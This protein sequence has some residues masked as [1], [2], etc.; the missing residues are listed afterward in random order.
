MYPCRTITPSLLTIYLGFIQALYGVNPDYHYQQSQIY[1]RAPGTC[2]WVL[3]HPRYV[4]WVSGQ[5][6]S[7]LWITGSPGLGKTVLA[8]FLTTTLSSSSAGIVCSFYFKSGEASREHAN[9]ALC[10]L[11]HQLW[12]KRPDLIPSKVFTDISGKGDHFTSI[13]DDLW[14]ALLET[15]RAAPDTPIFCI[16]DGLDEC[17][18]ASSS[19]LISHLRATFYLNNSNQ[20]DT[21]SLNLKF[22]ITSRPTHDIERSFEGFEPI[23][24]RGEDETI[25]VAKDVQTAISYRI[26]EMRTA[27]ALRPAACKLLE[28]RLSERSNDGSFL[29]VHLIFEKIDALLQKNRKFVDEVIETAPKDLYQLYESEL[30]AS[31]KMQHRLL[32]IILAAKRPLTLD[33]INIAMYI[34][35]TNDNFND[36]EIISNIELGVKGLG[37]ILIRVIN[38][39]VHLVH[40]TA[41][42]YLLNKRITQEALPR[43]PNGFS[44]E[45][46]RIMAEACVCFLACENWGSLN[47]SQEFQESGICFEHQHPQSEHYGKHR[48]NWYSVAPLVQ[49]SYMDAAEQELLGAGHFF[50]YAATNWFHH[51]S[52]NYEKIGCSSQDDTLK[53]TI[54]RLC[55]VG[56]QSKVPWWYFHDDKFFTPTSFHYWAAEGQIAVLEGIL[57]SGTLDINCRIFDHSVLSGAIMYG[58]DREAFWLIDH[59]H[60][61]SFSWEMVFQE[62]VENQR[63][64]LVSKLFQRVESSPT[65]LSTILAESLERPL[66][67]AV[68]KGATTMVEQLLKLGISPT[69]KRPFE[70]AAYNAHPH[71]LDLLLLH[72]SSTRSGP[73]L[74]SH[75]QAALQKAAQEDHDKSLSLGPYCCSENLQDDKVRDRLFESVN[76]ENIA[77]VNSF[78]RH[79]RNSLR[80][81]SNDLDYTV[82]QLPFG[83]LDYSLFELEQALGRALWSTYHL[84]SIAEPVFSVATVAALGGPKN[85]INYGFCRGHMDS[86][87]HRSLAEP[88][89][90]TGR[91][92]VRM[93]KDQEHFPTV[94]RNHATK[95]FL[96]HSSWGWD[97]INQ[98][99]TGSES[100]RLRPWQLLEYVF[101]SDP[102]QKFVPTRPTGHQNY[103]PNFDD[104]H[105]TTKMN[106]VWF[107]M[108][109]GVPALVKFARNFIYSNSLTT[110]EL[111]Y[112]GRC[113][114]THM[115]TVGTTKNPLISACLFG[116]EDLAALFIKLGFPVNDSTSLVSPSI[117]SVMSGN[118]K[119]VQLLQSYGA[120]MAAQGAYCLPYEHG[121]LRDFIPPGK[122]SPRK[123]IHFMA[124]RSFN[125]LR[126]QICLNH[127]SVT[128]SPLAFAMAL[129]YEDIIR[130]LVF[131]RGSQISVMLTEVIASGHSDATL[132]LLGDG[133]PPEASSKLLA[134]FLLDAMLQDMVDVSNRLVELGVTLKVLEDP[135]EVFKY[136]L[137]KQDLNLLQN[138]ARLG[139]DLHIRGPS[140]QTLLHDAAELG[141]L[142]IASWLLS[143]KNSSSIHGSERETA[144]SHMAT[145]VEDDQVESVCL[146]DV[147]FCGRTPLQY[148]VASGQLSIAKLLLE[149]KASVFHVDETGRSVLND[150][151]LSY[152]KPGIPRLLEDILNRL[153]RSIPPETDSYVLAEDV[154][155]GA[156]RAGAP[157]LLDIFMSLGL[158]VRAT[159]G[160]GGKLL[161][162]AIRLVGSVSGTEVHGLAVGIFE[163][164]VKNSG[165][166]EALVLSALKYCDDILAELTEYSAIL[167]IRE[168][169]EKLVLFEDSSMQLDEVEWDDNFWLER[170]VGSVE[171]GSEVESP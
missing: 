2:E 134:S 47:L 102:P 138:L 66:V 169:L 91:P 119:V 164:L 115:V 72:A 81:S 3:E 84:L 58:H 97:L 151:V 171:S 103:L 67:H 28:E 114:E 10:T 30:S 44:D 60:E 99:S 104:G 33:E 101:E 152:G 78:I 98:A 146:E 55:S 50:Q 156:I 105:R 74:D 125:S 142:N 147:D 128:G 76:S 34:E 87:F 23:R 71:I 42:E 96:E 143:D 46:H 26:T 37:G 111:Q 62:A 29:L 118:V 140:G 13:L 17:S 92:A 135:S 131:N 141:S 53:P 162:S 93:T 167:E 106:L 31:D 112:F 122:I 82:F 48:G 161:H 54:S 158:D 12:H 73:T 148:A 124:G 35:P 150:L 15:S 107:K 159:V 133:L 69:S 18:T 168:H 166:P 49:K 75:F 4:S 70:A 36:I 126:Q 80:D 1:D 19:R 157:N 39:R 40:E 108:Q 16:V 14:T 149:K 155:A 63:S 79:M 113:F 64:S 11:L 57:R 59:L 116:Q 41:R 165:P 95:S 83:K 52:E 127:V 163:S 51:V 89:T 86:I 170:D 68:Q 20:S 130:A 94:Y 88:E 77:L 56:V 137:I 144:I 139:L 109:T 21:K 120:D 110:N 32:Q 6:S 45:G 154:L 132:V 61:S 117:A 153:E 9:Q 121:Q 136:L 129:G 100:T 145:G 25:A 38:S 24:L 22:L 123:V 65:L 90:R 7:L 43:Q 8:K 5:S 85:E 160:D 27:K